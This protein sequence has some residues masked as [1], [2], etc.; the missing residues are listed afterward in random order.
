MDK[1]AGTN[2]LPPPS[3]GVKNHGSSQSDAGT[4]VPYETAR[5]LDNIQSSLISLFKNTSKTCLCYLSTGGY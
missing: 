1:A 3:T 2:N 4:K 5:S